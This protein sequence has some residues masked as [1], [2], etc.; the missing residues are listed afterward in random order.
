MIEEIK[1]VLV[2]N[3]FYVLRSGNCNIEIVVGI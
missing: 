1:T 3:M 2:K